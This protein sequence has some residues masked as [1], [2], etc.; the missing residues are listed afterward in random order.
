MGEAA[1]A[2]PGAAPLLEVEALLAAAT[3]A[4]ATVAPTTAVPAPGGGR[5]AALFVHATGHLLCAV[6]TAAVV[7]RLLELD[8]VT[9]SQ[10]VAVFD[11][12]EVAEDVFAPVVGLDEPEAAV[13]PAES[14]ATKAGASA[15]RGSAA[16]V[17]AIIA[18]STV[19]APGSVVVVS[20]LCSW[21]AEKRKQKTEQSRPRKAEEGL[22]GQ[23]ATDDGAGVKWILS[24]TQEGS[25]SVARCIKA[26]A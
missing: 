17:A 19:S 15:G 14:D 23:P 10:S 22:S 5:A 25:R 4:A 6:L 8:R 7:V 2:A 21:A 26:A 16:V 24:Q 9:L 11:G 20:H 12:G 18:V 13:V 3:A 1:G